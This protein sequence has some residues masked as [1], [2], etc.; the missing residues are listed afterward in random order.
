MGIVTRELRVQAGM[1]A[2]KSGW[3]FGAPDGVIS[4]LEKRYGIHG[5]E[6]ETS[7]ILHFR[8]DLVDMS[9]A[10]NLTSIAIR[11]EQEFKYP[12]PTGAFGHVYAWS[13]SDINPSGVVGEADLGTV[14]KG[15][16]IAERNVAGMLEMVAEV[17]RMPVPGGDRW[18]PRQQT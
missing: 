5:G 4:D 8:P 9:R 13:A 10:Q 2:V 15:R 18:T 14:E 6:S 7:L 17:K 11:D 3:R 1:L 12:R 16:L